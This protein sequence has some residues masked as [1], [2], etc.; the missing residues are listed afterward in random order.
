MFSCSDHPWREDKLA[1]VVNNLLKATL[2]H[3]C[4]CD[5]PLEGHNLTWIRILALLQIKAGASLPHSSIHPPPHL[6]LQA[7]RAVGVVALADGAVACRAAS[8]LAPGLVLEDVSEP[9]SK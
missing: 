8:L 2:G 6:E 7:L 4:S 5:Q 9:M 3:T 1:V